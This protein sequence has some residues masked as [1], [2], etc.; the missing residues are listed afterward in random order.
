MTGAP[1]VA[2]LLAGAGIALLVLL[3][4][5]AI[6]P[7]ALSHADGRDT[8]AYWN[9]AMRLREGEPLYVPGRPT[10]SDLYRYSPWFAYAWIPL[11][12]LPRDAVVVGWVGLMLAA[13][14][15]STAPL[16]ARGAAGVCA[17]AFLTPFQLDAA[18]Y[19]N[20]QPL[21]VLLLVWG[22]PRRSG[23]LSIA[24]GASLKA[25]PV[26]LSLV[27]F[28]K[29][30]HRRGVLTLLLTAVLTAPM[31]LHDL[32][33]YSTESG[34]AQMSLIAVSPL[35]YVAVAVAAAG[36]IL[37]VGRTRYAWLAGAVAVIAALPRLLTYEL[38]FLLIGA[39]EHWSTDLRRLVRRPASASLT[40]G[41][42][43]AT[44]PA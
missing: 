8:E 13:A 32:S 22:A 6:L 20:V 27:Y 41:R 29:G 39:A 11:T 31:L 42:D 40:R 1:P 17:F 38:G 35:L 43:A 3:T 36:A 44:M 9:A 30:E 5:A 28:A 4:A 7:A 19:G 25:V 33:G 23:P 18:A 2:R 16:L 24:I 12:F 37:A 21:L 10:D 34:R 26:V 15:L 14:L